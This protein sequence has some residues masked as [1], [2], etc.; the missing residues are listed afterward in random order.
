MKNQ[1]PDG[2]MSFPY[3]MVYLYH[4]RKFKEA[5]REL[6]SDESKI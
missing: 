1:F 4:M 6:Y 2:I 5:I 3:F